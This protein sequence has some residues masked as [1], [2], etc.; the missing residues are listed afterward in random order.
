M[1]TL[2][3][4]EHFRGHL[5]S[6][7]GIGRGD[8]WQQVVAARP[9]LLDL[10]YDRLEVRLPQYLRVEVFQK[11]QACLIEHWPTSIYQDV[12][13]DILLGYSLTDYVKFQ[14]YRIEHSTHDPLCREKL[15]AYV[16][17]L[18]ILSGTNGLQSD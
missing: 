11:A 10:A 3:G 15:G 7:R 12:Q 6:R 17:A 16:A 5:T 14:R 1:Q 4:V 8:M 13:V 2:V 9:H 18:L